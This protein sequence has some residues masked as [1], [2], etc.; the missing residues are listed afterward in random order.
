MRWKKPVFLSFETLL[1]TI[2]PETERHEKKHTHNEVDTNR[3]KNDTNKPSEMRIGKKN[4]MK[5]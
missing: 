1:K 2:T 3:N 5:P 4:F